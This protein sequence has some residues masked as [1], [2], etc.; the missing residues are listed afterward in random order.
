[1]Q[2]RSAYWMRRALAAESAALAA[3]S[4]WA[5]PVD[6]GRPDPLLAELAQMLE[7][8]IEALLY[9]A[10]EDLWLSDKDAHD[11][12]HSVLTKPKEDK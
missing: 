12:V 6:T 7:N 4:G 11:W 8:A 5:G 2:G 1:M 10:Q 3:A 9:F